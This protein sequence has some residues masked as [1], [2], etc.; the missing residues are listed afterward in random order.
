MDETN[1]ELLEDLQQQLQQ[2]GPIPAGLGKPARRMTEYNPFAAPYDPC[3]P[4]YQATAP[5]YPDYL[6]VG[7]RDPYA[8]AKANGFVGDEA[9]WL[10]TLKGP[11]GDPGSSGNPGP[12]GN[13]GQPGLP[14]ADGQP[15]SAGAKGDKGDVGQQGPP[16]DPSVLLSATPS[17]SKT[18]SSQK[19]VDELYN[20]TFDSR[21]AI[22]AYAGPLRSA[23][24]VKNAIP[25]EFRLGS[26][27]PVDNRMVL[28]ATGLGS[29]PTPVLGQW[30]CPE[31]P[32]VVRHFLADPTGQ[33][34][35]SAAFNGA[36][37]FAGTQ[38]AAVGGTYRANI[39]VPIGWYR[40]SSTINLTEK[41]GI[42]IQGKGNYINTGIIGN[43]SVVDGSGNRT[44]GRP[45]ID[46]TGSSLC[47]IENITIATSFSGYGGVASTIGVLGALGMTSGNSPTT[48]G[49]NSLR[50]KDCYI[51]MGDD[52][53]ANGGFGS[54]GFIGCR[55]EESIGRA[56]VIQA[57]LPMLLTAR[58]ALS[59]IIQDITG[60]GSASFTVTS[61]FA[62]VATIVGSMGVLDFRGMSLFSVHKRMPAI[63]CVGVNSM[64]FQGYLGRQ[65]VLPLADTT[66]G[67]NQIAIRT[68]GCFGLD[69]SGTTIES[70]STPLK[71]I[72]QLKGSTIHVET[73]NHQD[74][75]QPILDGTGCRFQDVVFTPVFGRLDEIAGRT[76]IYHAPVGGGNTA[77]TGSAV[78]MTVNC[79]DWV[80]NRLAIS[81]NLLRNFDGLMNTGQPFTKEGP[82]IKWRVTY[83][84]PA[85][86]AAA[87]A[88]AV[89]GR[90]G[91]ADAATFNVNNAGLYRIRIDCEVKGGANTST[92]QAMASFSIQQSVAQTKLGIRTVGTPIKTT[93]DGATTNGDYLTI[94]GVNYLL[95]FDSDGTGGFGR[96]A[97][98]PTVTGTATTEPLFITARIA[99]YSNFA[100][101]AAIPTT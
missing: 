62:N 31:S 90:F 44:A 96:M 57:N 65:V 101:K 46:A 21:A 45:V 72:G 27:L 30:V 91:V 58:P 68:Y 8:I 92:D 42:H 4:A 100:V 70:F 80:D 26:N 81:A 60:N 47:V 67:S 69:V 61:Q 75:S 22:D 35:S 51:D 15:G 79:T 84:I 87:P 50:L 2:L 1:Q 41:N 5:A 82:W 18:F 9:A 53:T 66:K 89:V 99:I 56:T 3:L 97:I 43:T 86:T 23:I 20:R 10:L 73:A 39:I 37:A 85:G 64:N 52:A 33:T 13:P 11:K 16:G 6:A 28:N 74:T 36:V 14:G 38:A 48:T 71:T 95:D 34:D 17:P 77:A 7:A 12:P 24:L 25:Y 29:L 19:I 40:V 54:I 49:G 55:C 32:D 59:D 98:T 83:N 88:T 93:L 94:T 63:V 76:M 78:N